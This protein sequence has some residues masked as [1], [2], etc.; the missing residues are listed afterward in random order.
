MLDLDLGIH[1]RPPW[2]GRLHSPAH[3]DVPA[4][5]QRAARCERWRHEQDDALRLHLPD[6][7]RIVEQ[8]GY[9]LMDLR[10]QG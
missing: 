4:V 7:Y 6:K 1:R 9:G 2:A 10:Q 5:I 8:E 3:A